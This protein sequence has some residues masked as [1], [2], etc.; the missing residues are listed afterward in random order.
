MTEMGIPELHH[1]LYTVG[2]ISWGGHTVD[3]LLQVRDTGHPEDKF[4]FEIM[5]KKRSAEEGNYARLERAELLHPQPIRRP[6]CFYPSYLPS[7][8]PSHLPHHPPHAAYLG[9]GGAV[10]FPVSAG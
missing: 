5:E 8:L 7:H 4:P 10:L 6:V 9:D 2:Q 3:S 1:S